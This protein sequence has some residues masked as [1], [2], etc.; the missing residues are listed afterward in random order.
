MTKTYSI[1]IAVDGLYAT[2]GKFQYSEGEGIR[3]GF[4]EDC[5]APWA[6]AIYTAIEEALTEGEP[7]DGQLEIEGKTYSWTL[8]AEAM[9]P[10]KDELLVLARAQAMSIVPATVLSEATSHENCDAMAIAFQAAADR[11]HFG[12]DYSHLAQVAGVASCHMLMRQAW[13]MWG[14]ASHI[15]SLSNKFDKY[16]ERSNARKCFKKALD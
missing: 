13:A 6:D 10:S 2:R 9:V 5:D 14:E 11:A 16:E 8:T 7:A 15:R 12:G 3:S 4:I 1:S